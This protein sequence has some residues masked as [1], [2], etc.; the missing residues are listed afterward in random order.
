MRWLVGD[1]QG[2]ARE[3]D[4]LLREIRYDPGHDE[5]WCLGDLVNRGPDSLAVVRTWRDI[6]GHGLIG[7]HEVHALLAH[8]GRKPKDLPDLATLFAAPDA[9]DLMDALRSLPVLVHLPSAGD[10]PD[11][12]AVHAGLDP[13]W[14]DLHGKAAE[15]NAGPHDDD[16]LL[17]DDVAYAVHVRCCTPDGARTR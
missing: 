5:L 12:W 11:V 13:R 6:G 1:I 8:S 15:L 7:N 4:T 17:R 2:C 3:F 9:D 14:T 10:G 16:R